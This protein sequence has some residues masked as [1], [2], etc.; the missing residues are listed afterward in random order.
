MSLYKVK[1]KH[2][3]GHFTLTVSADDE[4]AAAWLACEMEGAPSR[5]VLLVKE[6]T[7]A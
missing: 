4:R 2:D 7:K 3:N 5:S 1:M 6:V